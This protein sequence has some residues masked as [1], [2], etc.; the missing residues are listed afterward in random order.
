[1]TCAERALS[2]PCYL[3]SLELNEDMRLNCTKVSC[4]LEIRPVAGTHD[5]STGNAPTSFTTTLEPTSC[6]NVIRV[7]P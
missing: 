5:T 6:V 4:A 7:T 2:I 3:S 1:M